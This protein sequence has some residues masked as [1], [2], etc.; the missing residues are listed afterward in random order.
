M[1]IDYL[2]QRFPAKADQNFPKLVFLVWKYTSHL[3]TLVRNILAF[4]PSKEVAFD[5]NGDCSIT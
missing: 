2:Y 5:E 1:V 3:A 4:T